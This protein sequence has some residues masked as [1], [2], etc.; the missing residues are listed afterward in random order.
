M[1]KGNYVCFFI[2]FKIGNKIKNEKEEEEPKEKME[3]DTP[4]QPP[5]GIYY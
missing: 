3:I 5:A 4:A 1:E 2:H